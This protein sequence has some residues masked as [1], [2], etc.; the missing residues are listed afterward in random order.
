LIALS[1]SS[2]V[3]LVTVV[4]PDLS[5]SLPADEPR[6]LESSDAGL[7]ASISFISSVVC[8]SAT[9]IAV[10]LVSLA[11][12]LAMENRKIVVINIIMLFLYFII[13]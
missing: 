4:E 9:A 2:K 1:I 7:S 12:T 6:I 5:I 11:H 10:V 3:W 8:S 13:I